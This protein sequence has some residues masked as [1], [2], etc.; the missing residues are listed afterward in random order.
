MKCF[1]MQCCLSRFLKRVFE[2]I[3]AFL[4]QRLNTQSQMFL[5]SR[6]KALFQTLLSILQRHEA[7]VSNNDTPAL[8]SS[9]ISH[10]PISHE[11]CSVIL[12]SGIALSVVLHLTRCVFVLQACSFLYLLMRSNFE[13]TGTQGCDRVH[14]Q[15]RLA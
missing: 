15:V 10:F 2:R 6:G 12:F 3:R 11:L 8:V 13:F 1:S 14:W 7:I 5:V 9:S 4:C